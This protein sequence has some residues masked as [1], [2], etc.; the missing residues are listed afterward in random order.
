[1]FKK[2]RIK[3]EELHQ[4]VVCLSFFKEQENFAL[5]VA[6]HL[7]INIA[8]DEKDELITID[9]ADTTTW[10]V[11][12][13]NEEILIK[14]EERWRL[15]DVGTKK[16]ISTANLLTY[17]PRDYVLL[18][19]DAPFLTIYETLSVISWV[20]D[21]LIGALGVVTSADVYISSFIDGDIYP[22]NPE[23]R[24]KYNKH[25][26]NGI[27]GRSVPDLSWLLTF[28]E[29]NAWAKD[30][31]ATDLAKL[32]EKLREEERQ[33][34]IE[35]DAATPE[36]TETEGNTPE[37][38]TENAE[39]SIN[40]RRRNSCLVVIAALCEKAGVKPTERSL[41]AEL[42]DISELSGEGRSADTIRDILQEVAG[43]T[44]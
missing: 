14:D 29:A 9:G 11:D 36:A 13:T 2:L 26:I 37:D 15:K 27:S 23:T 12:E 31:F 38:C 24:A 10:E 39:K 40:Q 21:T 28:E 43:Y 19:L 32:R 22:R 5:S 17:L 20:N 44:K 4:K 41:A 30:V 1:V 25:P 18:V 3:K 7:N 6:E 42:A 8:I 35:A 33:K 34:A 16:T